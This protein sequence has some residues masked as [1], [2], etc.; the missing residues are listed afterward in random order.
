MSRVVHLLLLLF[1]LLPAAAYGWT[2]LIENGDLDVDADG[3]GVADGW[4]HNI[5][6]GARGEFALDEKEKLSGKASQKIVH[7]SDD[8]IW[9]R[10]SQ[11]PIQCKPNTA[12]RLECLVKATCKYSVLLYEFTGE[13]T[14]KTHNLGSGK[15]SNWKKVEGVIRTSAGAKFF[16]VSLITMGKG[17][18]WFDAV[19]LI[20]LDE[21]PSVMIPPC[22]KA[23]KIDGVLDDP[24][25]R[26]AS[27]IEPFFLLNGGGKLPPAS[28]VAYICQDDEKLYIAFRCSEPNPEKIVAKHKQHDA[29]IH[30]DDCVEVFLAPERL[31]EKYFHL[32]VNA[33]GTRYDKRHQP[34]AR[35]VF[36]NRNWF[37]PGMAPTR[38]GERFRLP[39]ARPPEWNPRWQAAA[40]VGEKEWTVE[41]AIPFA[42]LGGKP[43]L[44]EVWGANFCR[45]RKVAG[46]ENSC[47]A[48]IVGDTFHAPTQ[49]G[50][51]IFGGGS[52]PPA[53]QVAPR[54]PSK[55]NPIIVPNPQQLVWGE[56]DFEIGSVV[57]C[58]PAKDSPAIRA[59]IGLLR[60]DMEKRF[61]AKLKTVGS[62]TEP[63]GRLFID[64]EPLSDRGKDLLKRTGL[65]LPDNEE[66]YVLAV[67]A[68]GVVL[69]GKSARGCFNGVQT[70]R[71][72]A[73]VRDGKRVF[74]GV[75]IVDYPDMKFRGWHS[76]SP[77]VETVDDYRKF[78]D[79]LAL[80][81]FNAVMMEVNNRLKYERHPDIA[82][83][84]ALTK[85]ELRA[86]VEY[87][88]SLQFEVIPQVQTLGHFNYVLNN[89]AYRHLAEN[90]EPHERRGFW[91]YC[92]S[93]PEVYPLVF[94]MFSEVIEVFKPKRFFHI[95]HDEFTFA[96]FG[97]CER[98]KGTPPHQL[99]AMEVKKLHDWLAK[100]GLRTLM[101]G[102]QFLEDHHGGPPYNTYKATP[103]V[104]KDIIICDWHY[105]PWEEFPS[106]KYFKENGFE[107]IACGWYNPQNVYNFTHAA[108]EV[109]NMGYSGTTWYGIDRIATSP[110]LMCAIVMAA[111]N[112]WSNWKPKREE[113]KYH[114]TDRFR[115]LYNI[116]SKPEPA[117]KY[118]VRRLDSRCNASLAA[119]KGEVDC[120]G[121]GADNDLSTL[122]R[123]LQWLGG[124][125][126]LIGE[127]A[128]ALA[129][130]EG[131][132]GLPAAVWQIP[133]GMK[134]KS[135]FFLHTTTRP[136]STTDHIYH[137]TKQDPKRVG[138]YVVYFD[139]GARDEIL[140]DYR[141][142]ITHWNNR[143]GTS[144]AR[145]VWR[146]HTKSG[147]LIQLC[148]YEWKNPKPNVRIRTID[149][150]SE[151]SGVR[152][153]LIALTGKR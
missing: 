128:I 53:E 123:G 115:E 26:I 108:L 143:L 113:M 22:G 75:K 87:A 141:R 16:K 73:M 51:I 4:F 7:I 118:L 136:A 93:N 68:D 150:R 18:A 110:E 57:E 43:S 149:F 132:A 28:T 82:T 85:D 104:P 100:H 106:L 20:A 129:G 142:V 71:Q 99:F 62:A 88:R 76:A 112:T 121:L 1:V 81:K 86:V 5:H 31:S 140:L 49:F 111:E 144:E 59:G 97:V 107:T 44:G 58:V 14:Y 33:I 34:I 127:K 83:S 78:L 69:I 29:P 139:D 125:P 6:S 146:G 17:E 24:C 91:V 30:S 41:M 117:E 9:V 66:G 152:P 105:A 102:D 19:R 98:C 90:R 12:Y 116:R 21:K 27:R 37:D 35:P 122:P 65:A 56:R 135:L 134:A 40:K 23:P 52:I 8:D 36:F 94:D 67:D 96:P 130:K 55:A 137:R 153:I 72:L 47:W 103:L 50:T 151:L 15:A 77:V 79:M 64:C 10:M 80:L 92:P 119:K 114:P 109:G 11:M 46:E 124:V 148:A 42:E 120:L 145:I 70:V 54:A 45:E 133:V 32:T 60:K 126:F 63:D 2:N 13:R 147:A 74:R 48:L 131:D 25:W 89:P 3:N 84:H 138:R 38:P 95:G 39:T 61:D 101:W